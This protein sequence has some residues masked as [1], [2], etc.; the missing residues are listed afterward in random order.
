MGGLVTKR[1]RRPVIF[2]NA[3]ANPD[4]GNV[5]RLFLITVVHL[6]AE[7]VDGVRRSGSS[8]A[9]ASPVPH[10]GIRS[11]YGYDLCCPSIC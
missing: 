10:L 6:P 2:R 8:V 1:D 7:Y 11:F 9:G 4:L 5:E 3:L